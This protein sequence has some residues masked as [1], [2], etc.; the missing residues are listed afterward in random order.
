MNKIKSL[1]FAIAMAFMP[2]MAFAAAGDLPTTVDLSAVSTYGAVIV[3]SLVG[4]IVIRK[5][6]KLTN[7]S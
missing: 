7:R 2:A 4:L 3:A 1:L 6:I 5:A